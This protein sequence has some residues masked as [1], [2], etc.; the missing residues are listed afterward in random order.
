MQSDR[1]KQNSKT[2]PFVA[3][4]IKHSGFHFA[5]L[6]QPLTPKFKPRLQKLYS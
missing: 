6:V 3:S 4:V 1:F 5:F 2:N